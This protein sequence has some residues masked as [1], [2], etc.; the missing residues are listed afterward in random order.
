MIWQTGFP[1][2]ITGA[3]TGAALARPDRVDGVPLL[4]PENL[5]GWYDGRT[6]GHAAERPR[7]HAAEPD[8]SEI[9]PGCVRRPRRHDA[10]RPDRGRSV[11]VRQRGH[12]YD[13]IRTDN[14]FN[15]DMSI[16]REFPIARISSS[17]APT[18]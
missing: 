17:S 11:L 18:R 4:L 12:T 15:I 7:H 1:I 10:E 6:R 2:A 14:R 16:R 9:Q 3:S 13:E 5:W 8:L